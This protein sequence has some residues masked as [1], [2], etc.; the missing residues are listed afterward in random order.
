[1]D[2]HVHRYGTPQAPRMLL[3]HGMTE[4][5][6]TWPDL[7][8][9]WGAVWDLLAVDLRGHGRSPRLT[10][11]ERPRATEVML[12]DVVALLDEQPAPVVLLGHSLGG[13]LALRAALRRPGAVR[14]L[15]LED[16]T[17]PLDPSD[18]ERFVAGN[19]A[20]LDAMA[21]RDGQVERMRAQ[22]RW[23]HAEIDAWADSK[24]RVDREAVTGGLAVRGEWD[25]LWDTIGVPTLVVVPPGPT[26]S[27]AAPRSPLVRRVV[28]PGAGHCVRRD[29]PEA[30]CSAVEDFLAAL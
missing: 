3:L 15:V 13:N 4:D 12:D 5:G 10:Q 24:A 9:R 28:V 1:M 26:M 6:T 29:E 18:T 30:F 25:A 27:P 14:A 8:E 11:D 21:D 16:P 7:V 22:T 19:L 2:L 20:F 17:S 23:S